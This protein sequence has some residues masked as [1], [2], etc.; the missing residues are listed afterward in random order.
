MGEDEGVGGEPRAYYRTLLPTPVPNRE[1]GQRV[2]EDAGPH[3]PRVECRFQLFSV[4]IAMSTPPLLFSARRE[5]PPG[6]YP[7]T[8]Q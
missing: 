5:V 1:V 4:S 3:A 8:Q 6:R 2:A 7:V